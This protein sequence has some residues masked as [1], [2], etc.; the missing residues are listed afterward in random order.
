VQRGPIPAHVNAQLITHL[1]HLPYFRALLRAVEAQYYV[2]LPLPHPVY[3]LGCGDGLFAA[4]ALDSRVD[5]GLDPWRGPIR[6]A[7][8]HGAY[9]LL[10]EAD[11]ARAP[12]ASASFASAFSNSVLEHVADIEGAIAET[13]RV[14]R[15]GAPF[16]FCVPN[17]RY[18]QHLSL[19]RVLGA[20]YVE[21]F[22]RITRVHN[23][24][25]P[26]AWKSRL[27]RAGLELVRWWHYFPPASMRVLEWGHYFGLPSLLIR[28]LT[29]RWVIAPTDW[30]LWL[31]R[32]LIE[33]HASSAPVDN[34]AFTFYIA[35]RAGG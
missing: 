1:R 32:R 20:P 25:E 9:R 14:L 6:E 8:G 23:L 29:G 28:V 5:V 4:L 24:D 18:L 12:F 17:P 10:T 34:G 21:W 35:R 30:N 31:T 11:A 13:G 19:R 33:R 26:E 3:D 2:E 7:R 16:Y 27:E 22:R 15:P